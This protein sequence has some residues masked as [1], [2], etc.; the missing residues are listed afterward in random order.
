[1]LETTPGWLPSRVTKI[2][3]MTEQE[4][5]HPWSEK[6]RMEKNQW[7]IWKSWPPL[8]FPKEVKFYLAQ[9][10]QSHFNHCNKI[11]LAWEIVAQI[12][13]VTSGPLQGK[14][15]YEWLEQLVKPYMKKCGS[16]LGLSYAPT[17]NNIQLISDELN[18]NVLLSPNGGLK[19]FE[20][21][22]DTYCRGQGI[23][24]WNIIEF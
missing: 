15:V 14:F 12:N 23:I 3:P 22:V 18:V 2:A 24:V 21:S 11:D 19:E 17:K 1:M 9:F 8:I 16:I 20:K 5:L 6:L 4:L 10:C 13:L 7:I